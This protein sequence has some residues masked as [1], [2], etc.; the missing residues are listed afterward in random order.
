MNIIFFFNNIMCVC[1]LS[2]FENVI[3]VLLI[4]GLLFVRD[5]LRWYFFCVG[6]FIVTFKRFFSRV[7]VVRVFKWFVGIFFFRGERKI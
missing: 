2:F 3:Y 5:I 1:F 7:V 4:V 6:N